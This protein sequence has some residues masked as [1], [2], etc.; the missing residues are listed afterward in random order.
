MNLPAFEP[1]VA[2]TY[3]QLERLRD[4]LRGQLK[5][6]RR[7]ELIAV[8]VYVVL[9]L[10]ANVLALVLAFALVAYT[11]GRVIVR[12]SDG[13][14]ALLL[15]VLLVL[16]AYPIYWFMHRKPVLEAELTHG[17]LR[18]SSRRLEAVGASTGSFEYELLL[19]PA[20]TLGQAISHGLR[21]W[22]IGRGDTWAMTR[23]LAHLYAAN[24]RVTVHDLDM[25]LG[26]PGLATAIRALEDQP[27][28]LFYTGDHLS[29][30]L[31]DELAATVAQAV[32]EG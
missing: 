13:T 23:V 28:L 5:A 16:A 21:L 26:E 10:V 3:G 19:F 14:G 20:W 15:P 6:R 12:L 29:L 8:G 2:L 1:R 18:L 7:D 27:G 22:H 24:C 25:A 17:R 31:N 32:R 9:T 4:W 11:L 30:S